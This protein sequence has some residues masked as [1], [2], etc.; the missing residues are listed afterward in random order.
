MARIDANI[1]IR[2]LTDEPADQAERAARL[3]DRL[4]AG[5]LT[6]TVDEIVVAE[7]VWTLSSYYRMARKEIA[8]S[9]LQLL[10]IDGFECRNGGVVQRALVL[11]EEKRIDF[12]DAL[13]C[14]S[15]LAAGETDIYSFDRDL[16]KVAGIRRIEPS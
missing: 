9:L 11:Y 7:V 2:Y 13:L 8:E 6:V 1:I 4:A 15:M 10:S 12:A 14:A 5:E 16:D 3:F